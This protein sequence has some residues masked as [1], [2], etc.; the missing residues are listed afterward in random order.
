MNYIKGDLLSVKTG[1]IIHG[2]NAQGVMGSGV[3]KS[4]RQKYPE[5]YDKYVQDINSGMR[6]GEVSWYLDKSGVQIGSAITQEFY[7]R[8]NIRYV[9]Y[10]AVDNTMSNVFFA[11]NW[12]NN[13]RVSMPTIGAG[14]GNGSWE[15]ISEIIKNQAKKKNFPLEMIDVYEL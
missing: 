6:L 12:K 9:S 5:A 4:V 10:D 15:V 13:V 1:F 11:A 14:L 2:C 3:A 7:G 8:E